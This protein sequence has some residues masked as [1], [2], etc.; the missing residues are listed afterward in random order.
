MGKEKN[1]ITP[2]TDHTITQR[3]PRTDLL[4]LGRLAAQS[5]CPGKVDFHLLAISHWKLEKR[6]V[7]SGLG[8]PSH[9]WSSE[10]LW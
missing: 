5:T 2:H 10:S 6:T 1:T 4:G 9:P 7:A 8:A 3:I